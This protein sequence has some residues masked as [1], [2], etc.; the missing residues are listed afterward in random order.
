M[1]D[2]HTT[3]CAVD[4]AGFGGM[5]RTRPNY[6]ALREGMY[7]SVEQ[8]FL[9]SGIPWEDCYQEGAGDGILALAP[10]TVKKGAFADRLPVALVS[11]LQAHNEAHPPEERI[12]M[13]LVLHAGEITRDGRG[14]TGPAIIHA[15]RLLE[16]PALKEAL[17]EST[18]VLAVMASVWFYDEVIRHH[19]EYAPDQYEEVAV[20]VKETNGFGWIRLPDGERRVPRES[21]EVEKRRS[22]VASAGNGSVLVTP[23][24]R[25]ATPEFFQVLDA[26]EAVPCMQGEHTRSLVVEQLRFSG[27]IRYFPN[28]RAHV[29]SILRTCLDFEG[30]VVELV[31]AISGQEP[32]G[33]V[34]L[35]HLMTLLTGAA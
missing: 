31:T 28:R 6:V 26:I 30:G 5:P 32:S 15:F 13:R 7:S 17:R 24:V 33:S 3:I 18:G 1:D 16:S 10:A 35:N 22:A 8:A 12:Q 19:R 11:A 4:I 27:A 14:V 9:R 20:E 23:V 2:E 29:M 21:R 25:P 34:P